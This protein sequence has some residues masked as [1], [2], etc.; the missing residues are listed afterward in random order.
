[1]YAAKEEKPKIKHNG[2]SK[3]EQLVYRYAVVDANGVCY[4]TFERPLAREAKKAAEKVA[5]LLNGTLF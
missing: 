5:L 1:M 3:R 2:Q 4:C